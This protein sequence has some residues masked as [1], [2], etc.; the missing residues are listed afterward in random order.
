MVAA[1]ATAETMAGV[2]LLVRQGDNCW[3]V[4]LGVSPPLAFETQKAA[5]EAA[6]ARA[7]KMATDGIEADVV[8]RVMTC[9]FGPNGSFKAVPTPRDMDWDDE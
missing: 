5:I 6:M 4:R 3:E 9:R 2:R 8:M 1:R 7:K